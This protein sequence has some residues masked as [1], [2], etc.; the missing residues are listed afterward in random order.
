[1]HVLIVGAGLMGL[2]TAFFL[3]RAG[4]EVTVIDRQSGP[5]RETSFANGAML[6]AS[7]ANPWNEPGVLWTA[8]RMIGREDAALLLR[9]RA[10]PGMW[11]WGLDFVRHSRPTRYLRNFER[12]AHLARYSLAEMGGIRAVVGGDYDAQHCGTMKLFRTPDE[13]AGAARL[14]AQLGAWGIQHEV[15]DAAGAVAR[16]PALAPIEDQLAGGLFFPQDESGDAQRFCALIA[17]WLSAQGVSVRYG[18]SV[19]GLRPQS[20]RA[21]VVMTREGE[22]SADAVV[23]AAGS[24]SPQLAESVGLRIPVVP[25]KG[26]SLT[27]PLNG[28]QEGPRMPVIDDHLHAA[29]C[30]LGDRLRVAGTA[31][32]AGHDLALTPARINNLF[33]LVSKLYPAF[34]PWLRPELATRWTGLRPMSSDGVGIMGRTPVPGLF[35]NTGHGHLGWTMAAG[36]GHL[37]ADEITG[38]APALPHEVYHLSRFTRAN[39][40]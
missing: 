4:A 15:I 28:W 33:G 13:V 37:V 39:R 34:R 18:L 21:P 22:L 35:L 26:Y 7:Q 30:P 3:R 23:L 6:H 31:E 8:L 17:D 40:D 1:M 19:L 29:V 32:F 9:P 27:L 12:N 16:E 20:D 5:G 10:L 2:T 14:C 38:Q 24:Y 11:R 36:A 25:V